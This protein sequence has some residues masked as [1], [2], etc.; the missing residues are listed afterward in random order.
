MPSVRGVR[1]V[2]FESGLTGVRVLFRKP[3]DGLS[4]SPI[5]TDERIGITGPALR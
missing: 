1:I 2:L 4:F 3:G 5:E